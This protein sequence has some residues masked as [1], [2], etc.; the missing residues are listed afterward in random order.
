MKESKGVTH[1][2][3]QEFISECH[4]ELALAERITTFCFC[5][6]AGAKRGERRRRLFRRNDEAI[7]PASE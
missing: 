1:P 4:C 7:S 5:G 2:D 6:D 3:G